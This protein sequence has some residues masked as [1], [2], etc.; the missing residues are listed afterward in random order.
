MSVGNLDSKGEIVVGQGTGPYNQMNPSIGAGQMVWGKL[1]AYG[2]TNLVNNWGTSPGGGFSLWTGPNNAAAN[3]LSSIMTI[4]PLVTAIPGTLNCVAVTT[5]SINASGT[6]TAG[7]FVGAG[8]T[9]IGGLLLW[10]GGTYANAGSTIPDGY[11]VCNGYN[12]Q[13]TPNPY[14]DLYAVIGTQYNSPMTPSG[15]WSLPNLV[16]R[17]ASGGM[18]L[19]YQLFCTNAQTLQSSVVTPWGRGYQYFLLARGDFITSGSIQ[20]GMT[21]VYADNTRGPRIVRFF[22]AYGESAILN[23][24]L[25]YFDGPVNPIVASDQIGF[26]SIEQSNT[27]SQIGFSQFHQQSGAN[28]VV[29]EPGQVGGHNHGGTPDQQSTALNGANNQTNR[30]GNSAYNNGTYT[31]GQGVYNYTAGGASKQNANNSMSVMGA[32]VPMMYL[33][34]Y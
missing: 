7:K 11:L 10:A 13:I 23:G 25:I 18:Y 4:N 14:P 15:F 21:L 17:T 22:D 28:W 2:N 29:Q 34:K 6:V 31:A 3:Q 8:V 26:I 9:P 19:A 20:L 32:T 16:N 30:G 12:I 24:G 5:S 27:Y 33:I 1:D